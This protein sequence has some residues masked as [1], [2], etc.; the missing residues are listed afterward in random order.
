MGKNRHSKDRMFITATEW[1]VEYGGKKS[2]H[3]HGYQP[4]PFDHCALGL[5]PFVTPV[6]TAEGVIFDMENLVPYLI[7]HKKNPVTGDSMTAKDII[8]LNMVKNNDGLW[9]CPVT[10]K[11]FNNNSHVVAIRNTGNVYCF[12]AVNEL[13]IKAKNFSDLIT[14]EKFSKPDIITLQDPSNAE[15]TALRDINNFKHLTELRDTAAVERTTAST[16]RHNPTTEGIMREIQNKRKAEEAAGVVKKSLTELLRKSEEDCTDIEAIMA[17]RPLTEDVT[18]GSIM[19]EQ[20]MG[21]SLTSTAESVCTADEMRLA[22]PDEV[23]E[24]RYRK[25]RQLGKKGYVQLQTSLGNVNVELHCDW[26]PRTCWNF[27]TLCQRGYFDNTVFHRLVK[28][29]MIQGGDPTGTGT[30]GESAWG[31]GKPFRDEF[32]SRLKHEGRGVLSMA[33][34][35]ENTNKSQFFITFRGARHLDLVH[36][37][38][39]KVVGG[40]ATLDR[41]EGVEVGKDEVPKT[42]IKLL[43]TEVFVNPIEEADAALMEDIRA[44]MQRRKDS[45]V[46][47]A[48]LAATACIVDDIHSV[49]SSALLG[50]AVSSASSADPKDGPLLGP[51]VAGPTALPGPGPKSSVSASQS[52]SLLGIG[53]T[54]T[55]SVGK[56][57]RPTEPA[58]ADVAA[59]MRSQAAADVQDTVGESAAKKKR[60]TGYSNFSNW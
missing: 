44:S 23:R 19:S 10:F 53:G 14:G 56:G 26:A 13:N 11:V 4:L 50:P 35:G 30:G 58:A 49:R 12:D 24:A 3:R 8:R 25:M 48:P 1:K 51:S 29:F 54:G 15:L 9:H 45:Q 60:P 59:F 38:F 17:L 55:G 2:S 52:L 33:N 36:S 7:A 6:C 21:G 40:A 34:S 32:D 28:D 18:P 27:V 42:E 5:V 46:Q 57:K 20:R 22:R 37:I 41:I 16:V 39:G 43:H 31:P 47:R